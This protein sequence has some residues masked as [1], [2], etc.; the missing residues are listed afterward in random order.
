MSNRFR[1]AFSFA[2]EK[3]TFVAEVAGILAGHFTKGSIL[4]DKYHEA[5]F[6]RSDLA[7]HLPTLYFEETDLVVAVLC[8]DYDQKEWCGLEWK[9]IYG[10]LKKHEEREVMLCRFDQV[11]VAGLFELAGFV[12]LDEKTP[13]ELATLIMQRLELNEARPSSPDEGDGDTQTVTVRAPGAT[14]AATPGRSTSA[15]LPGPAEPYDPR[16]PPFYVPHHQKGSLVVG[17]EAALQRVRDQLVSGRRTAIGQTAVFQ[18]LGGLGKTQLAVEYAY[19]YRHAYPNG[20][21][22]LTADLDID[23]Q[24]V[25]VAVKSR[26]VAPESEHSL[27]LEIARHRLRSYSKC[28][29]VFDNLER[30]ESIQRYLPELP[31]EP[32]ILATSRT[33]QPDF[34]LVPIDVLDGDQSLRLLTLESGREPDNE[35]DWEGGCPVRC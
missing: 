8:N 11:E 14:P 25:D 6:A 3:R 17:R 18:G 5:E 35:A 22:W 1:I 34:V 9:A 19:S 33:E 21:I 29:V 28:L 10:R 13:N 30:I 16:N 31:A 2:G 15:S 27:K 7:L 20:V 4:Y 24:L 26:W 23:A 12:E 32:H